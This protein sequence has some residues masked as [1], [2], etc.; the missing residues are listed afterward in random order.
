MPIEKKDW[1]NAR[2][3]FEDLLINNLVTAEFY[4]K[5]IEVCQEKIL[6]FDDEED[7][8]IE[9]EVKKDLGI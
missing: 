3:Q 9:K 5:N 8:R 2:K 7:E 4:K 1:I 6:E